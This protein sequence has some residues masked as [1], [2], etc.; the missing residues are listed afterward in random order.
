MT[1]ET[2]FT[3]KSAR[4]LLYIG[5]FRDVSFRGE[6]LFRKKGIKTFL[7]KCLV[8]LYYAK[9]RFLYYIQDYQVPSILD[10]G[11]VVIARK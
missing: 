9:I 3:E 6:L 10:P 11:L 2:G 5:G 7:R 8:R 4:Q 1:H